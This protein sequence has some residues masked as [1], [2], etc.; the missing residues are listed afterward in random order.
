MTWLTV[1][2]DA[3][4]GV[5]ALMFLLLWFQHRLRAFL[6]GAG[7]VVAYAIS[8]VVK[9]V[10][11]EERP[12]RTAPSMAECPAPG[13]WSFPSNHSVIAGAS[14]M[15]IWALHRTYG[16]VAAVCAIAA[17][18]SRVVVGVH[19]VHDVMAGLALGALVSWGI[20]VLLDRRRQRREVA[21]APTVVMQRLR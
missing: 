6:A 18:S 11:R 4:L 10:V 7:V 12:C 17:A 21:D 3:V 13:D 5:F 14:A 19:Y 20:A 1:G 15:A 9:L 16:W 8:E 2:T